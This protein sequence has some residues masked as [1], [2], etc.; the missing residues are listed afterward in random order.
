MTRYC[1]CQLVNI[2]QFMNA[3]TPS[4]QHKY[5]PC[6]RTQGGV[7]QLNAWGPWQNPSKLI[8]GETAQILEF[9]SHKICLI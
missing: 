3:H 9:S 1:Q 8:S 7:R 4:V 2:S 5:N 6:E